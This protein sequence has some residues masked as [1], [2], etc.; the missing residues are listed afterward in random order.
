[1]F[2]ELHGGILRKS[3]REPLA[4]LERLQSYGYRRLEIAG[5]PVTPAEAAGLDVARIVCRT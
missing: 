5:R 2:L 1:M 3:G 4:V